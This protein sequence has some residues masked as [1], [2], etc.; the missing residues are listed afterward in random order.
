MTEPVVSN[1]G[2]QTTSDVTGAVTAKAV[3]A[4]AV[5]RLT[6]PSDREAIDT[7]TDRAY[8]Q[9]PSMKSS[10]AH[11]MANE[12]NSAVELDPATKKTMSALL[13]LDAT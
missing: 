3:S 8:R 10:A 4:N 13:A 6:A 2:R 5:S 12:P 9:N 1:D 7:W 11:D